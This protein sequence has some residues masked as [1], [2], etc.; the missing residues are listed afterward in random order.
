M[1]L[2]L[3]SEMRSALLDDDRRDT[4]AQRRGF[5]DFIRDGNTHTVAHVAKAIFSR[6]VV[7]AMRPGFR[8][9]A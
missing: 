9:G 7:R 8:V 5:D 2:A 1:P 6:V 3:N 4:E